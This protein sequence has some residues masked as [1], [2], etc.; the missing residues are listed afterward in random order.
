M[1]EKANIELMTRYNQWMNINLYDL[2]ASL[3]HQA[4]TMDRGAFFKSIL[5]TLNHLVVTD[6]IWMKRFAAHHPFGALDELDQWQQPTHL[7]LI[8]HEDLRAL[9]QDREQLD[10]MLIGFANEITESE[11]N[12]AMAYRNMAGQPFKRKVG[13]LFL[14]VLNH[15]THH[16]GQ[17]TTLF[18]QLG[19][20]P[21]M[22]DLLA[23]I[24][25]AR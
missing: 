6:I 3:D 20:D 13:Q 8:L 7:D 15:Q 25:E 12:T 19:I 5:G 22:T 18:S 14:H 1:S 21:G 2:A 4:L 17:L 24:P 23:L 11:L 9:K 10:M 16:R